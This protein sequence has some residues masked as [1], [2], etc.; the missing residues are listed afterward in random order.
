MIKKYLT[1][2]TIPRDIENEKAMNAGFTLHRGE[3]NSS[4]FDY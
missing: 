3:A 2:L 4:S 1:S